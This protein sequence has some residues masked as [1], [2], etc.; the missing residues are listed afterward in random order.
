MNVRLTATNGTVPSF[1]ESERQDRNPE[2]VPSVEGAN[3]Q[4]TA[5]LRAG[6]AVVIAKGDALGAES[7]DAVEDE[8]G[9]SR[10]TES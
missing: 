7:V 2:Q 5:R 6:E 8:Q 9:S 4:G 10:W 1:V 3:L